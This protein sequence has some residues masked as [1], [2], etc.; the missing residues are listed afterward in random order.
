MWQFLVEDVFFISGRGIVLVGKVQSG[1][2]HLG[3][4]TTITNKKGVLVESTVIGI[5]QFHNQCKSINQG[6]NCGLLLSGLSKGDVVAGSIIT[7][8]GSF[9]TG[10]D[11]SK[12]DSVLN[13][14][15]KKKKR[16]F[17]LF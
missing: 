7:A 13:G 15:T 3:D 11:Y 2:I 6:E 12:Q 9:N 17:G 10:F 16:F 5:E 4:V 1:N 14:V 8:S